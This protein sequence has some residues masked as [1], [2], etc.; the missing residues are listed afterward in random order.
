MREFADF[1]A[2]LLTNERNI[3]RCRKSTFYMAAKEITLPYSISRAY[4][5]TAK[6]ET[7]GRDKAKKERKRETERW[8]N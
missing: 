8:L 1:V 5:A 2:A 7:S 3:R 4:T 6:K